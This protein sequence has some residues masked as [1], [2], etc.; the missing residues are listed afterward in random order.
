MEQDR[1][2]CYRA[3][4]KAYRAYMGDTL[5]RLGRIDLDDPQDSAGAIAQVRELLASMLSHLRHEDE[6][7]HPLLIASGVIPESVPDHADHVLEM[8]QI[9][10]LAAAVVGAPRAD[11]DALALQLYHKLSIF[12]AENLEHMLGEE[13]NNNRFLWAAYSDELIGRVHDALVASI[14]P[15]ELMS[16]MTWMLPALTPSEL[17][18]LMAHVRET[19]PPPVFDALMGLVEEKVSAPRVTR[20]RE[21]LGWDEASVH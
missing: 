6:Y 9:E 8:A 18:G 15:Q 7:L 11:R 4:H 14:P 2:D 10:A 5:V 1:H 12:M 3:I 16:T 19:A 17:A 13:R 20:L 21:S